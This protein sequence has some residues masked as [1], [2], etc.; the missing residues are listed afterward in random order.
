MCNLS[1]QI[2]LS[3][4]KQ[5]HWKIHFMYRMQLNQENSIQA[6]ELMTCGGS[7]TMVI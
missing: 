3:C 7:S 5:K 1:P 4:W 2:I 6:K